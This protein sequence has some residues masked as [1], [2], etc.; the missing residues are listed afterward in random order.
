[1]LKNLML[2]VLC[3]GILTACGKEAAVATSQKA[4]P[5]KQ[6]P[7][8]DSC[9]KKARETDEVKECRALK[10]DFAEPCFK[11]VN[12]YQALCMAGMR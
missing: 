3:V 1:M 10:G 8:M 9:T 6:A 11:L 5:P 2:A 7:T 12:D 4:E